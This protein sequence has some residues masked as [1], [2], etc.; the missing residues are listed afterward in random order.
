MGTPYGPG[1][2]Q[3]GSMLISGGLEP[4]P[5]DTPINVT[6]NIL[7]QL[8]SVMGL[9]IVPWHA[10]LPEIGEVWAHASGTEEGMTV[11]RLN[12]AVSATPDSRDFQVIF[13][14]ATPV[15]FQGSAET[16]SELPQSCE[17]CLYAH[18]QAS[19]RVSPAN[20]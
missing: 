2:M 20:G 7:F 1:H 4:P 11:I 16:R 9:K 17:D 18:R 5:V 19:G 3:M 14:V 13:T 12:P 10:A 15:R 8:V 6:G